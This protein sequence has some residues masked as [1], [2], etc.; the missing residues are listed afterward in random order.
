M[1]DHPL[2]LARSGRSS[3]ERPQRTAA[4][5]RDPPCRAPRC[6]TPPAPPTPSAPDRAAP[7]PPTQMRRRTA[8]PRARATGPGPQQVRALTPSSCPA[9]RRADRAPFAISRAVVQNT[10][11]RRRH[12]SRPRRG[13]ADAEP[14]QAL[15]TS[16]SVP[17]SRCAVG[18]SSSTSGASRR[19]ARA[20]ATR[21]A[22]PPDRPQP[23]S[24]TSVSSPCGSASAK[25]RHARRAPRPRPPGRRRGPGEADIVAQA[26]R[27][28]DAAAARHRPRAAAIR[29]QQG[30]GVLAVDRDAA[31]SGRVKPIRM[32]S[33]E[34]LP[35]PRGRR[36]P[37]LPGIGAER[38][39]VEGRRA[40]RVVGQP[41]IGE[42]DH[43][44]GRHFLEQQAGRRA[45]AS[46]GASAAVAP[47]AASRSW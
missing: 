19:K 33:T 28:R 2:R 21:C 36:A 25:S 39:P 41:H 15:D 27:G 44:A 9:M 43:H 7:S 10:C 13:A 1:G 26:R 23:P 37:R 14:A 47:A 32:R 35:A 38:E 46:S 31:A 3:H 18:S 30:H 4:E 40:G 45:S 20:M 29:R 6:A 11:R 22:W 8:T 42:G 16:A 24:P 5:G 12:G 17:G 34:D